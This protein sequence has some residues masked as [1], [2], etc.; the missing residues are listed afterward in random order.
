MD[1]IQIPRLQHVITS[2][3]F[4]LLFTGFCI[5]TLFIWEGH[6]GINLSD[7]A[8]LW[9]GAA[10]VSHGKVPL[11]DFYAYDPG[12][13]YFT[14]FIMKLLGNDGI[15]ASRIAEALIQGLGLF[16]ALFILIRELKFDKK[17][18]KF[19]Y[20]YI[21]L[22]TL[23]LLVWMVPL[24]KSFDITASIVLITILTYLIKTNTL[25]ASFWTGVGIGFIAI[26]GRNHGIYGVVSSISV[27]VYLSLTQ[28][29]HS[30]IAMLKCWLVGVLI[31]YIPIILMLLF[32]PGFRYAFFKSIYALILSKSTNLYLPILWPWQASTLQ[33]FIC[34]IFFIIIL[35]FVI[36]SLSIIIFQKSRNKK[37]ISS[38][39]AACAFLSLPYA[40]YVF[41]RADITHLALGIFPFLIG[42]Y[43][44]LYQMHNKF[45][46]ISLFSIIILFLLSIIVVLPLHPRMQSYNDN[47]WEYIEITGSQLKVDPDAK[48]NIEMFKRLINQ[49]AQRGQSFLVAP[50]NFGMYPIFNRTSPMWDLY[51]LFPRSLTDQN[52]DIERI[53]KANLGF[54]VIYDFALDGNEKRQFHNT[55]PFIFKYI[56]DN[57]ELIHD[58]SETQNVLI[59]KRK[60]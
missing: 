44:Y 3:F 60:T 23:T 14:A 35:L 2:N 24:Y 29:K 30:I 22:T 4:I 11:R 7:E 27:L 31:G 59:Y 55:H 1:S 21:L 32:M 8:F 10:A 20:I 52:H 41:S 56:V 45:N 26:I 36:C 39:L 48:N 28:R 19:N 18:K 40:H 13:Y 37:N 51:P 58:I 33:G 17:N 5:I 46:I 42:F 47:H 57:F 25:A 54:A 15:I 53:K 6:F 9:Y 49:Y 43:T 12:R 50:F 34:G 16:L 38:V